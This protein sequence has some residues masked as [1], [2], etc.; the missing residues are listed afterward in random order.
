[1][2]ARS[3]LLLLPAL[4]A[5]LA[6]LAGTASPARAHGGPPLRVGVTGA[7]D[8]RALGRIVLTHLRDGVGYAVA[9][10]GFADAAGLRGAFAAAEADVVVVPRAAP[11]AGEGEFFALPFPAG[12]AREERAGVVVSRRLLADLRFTILGREIGALLG[13]LTP[14]DLAAVR[15]AEERGGERAAASAARAVVAGKR[16][17]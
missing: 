7:P 4:L 11:A 14:G 5:A 16:L 17:R 9:W 3:R 13:S 12:A 15:E 8:E 10:I 2:L 1:M 6:L